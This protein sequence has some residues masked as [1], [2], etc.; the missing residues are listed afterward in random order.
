MRQRI[1]RTL[2]PR[3][4]PW[5]Q[6]L[7]TTTPEAETKTFSETRSHLLEGLFGVA[8]LLS[9]AWECFYFNALLLP[10]PITIVLLV[11]FLAFKFGPARVR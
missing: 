5:R 11:L 10:G 3:G 8:T 7:R 6:Y 4:F 9:Y 2:A 1:I